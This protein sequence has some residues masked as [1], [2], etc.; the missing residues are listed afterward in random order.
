ML[1][2]L[3]IASATT[4]RAAGGR[5]RRYS[6]NAARPALVHAGPGQQAYAA[7]PDIAASVYFSDAASWALLGYPG[8]LK[9]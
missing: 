3:G 5:C 1:R 2:A 7:L 6:A 4:L 8:P 9:N